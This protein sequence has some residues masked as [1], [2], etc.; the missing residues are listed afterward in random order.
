MLLAPCPR[1]LVD[2]DITSLL[3]SQVRHELALPQWL[4][5]QRARRRVAQVRFYT[6][7]LEA[8]AVRRDDGIEENFH[9]NAAAQVIR[10]RARAAVARLGRNQRV[11]HD[12]TRGL[13]A[14]Y[15]HCL[16][17]VRSLRWVYTD[18]NYAI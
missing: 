13:I 6:A 11:V 10:N 18:T 4:A 16:P 7:A 2:E 1:V 14:T 8:V 17:N 15:L 3:Q 9:G 5:S 12:P